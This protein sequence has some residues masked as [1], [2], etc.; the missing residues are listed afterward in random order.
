[1]GRKRKKD[2]IVT[3]VYISKELLRKLEEERPKKVSISDIVE[4]M[5]EISLKGKSKILEITSEV[6]SLRVRVKDLLSEKERLEKENE[7]LQKKIQKLELENQEWKARWDGQKTLDKYSRKARE[8]KLIVQRILEHI[9]EGKKVSD[10]MSEAGILERSDQFDIAK[11]LFEPKLRKKRKSYYNVIEES[12]RWHHK[13][14][15][16]KYLPGWRTVGDSGIFILEQVFMREDENL[17]VQNET[18][19]TEVEEYA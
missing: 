13:E 1:M 3:S 18:S 14:Y 6:T 17:D 5:L 2:G 19:R 12:G 7:K 15:I 4:T 16:S 11:K 10:V 9:E 8:F